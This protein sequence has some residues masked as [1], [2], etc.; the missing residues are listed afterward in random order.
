MQTAFKS[1]ERFTQ[2]EFWEWLQERPESDRNRYELLGGHIIMTP[3]APGYAHSSVAIR[4]IVALAACAQAEGGEVLDSHAGFEFPTG[5]TLE[6]DVTFLSAARFAAG[7][8]PDPRRPLRIMPDLVIEIL[9]PSTAA[10]D[11]TEKKD[12]YA[13]CNVVEFWL[14][15]WRRR[16]V[17]VFLREGGGFG[18][19]RVLRA[20]PIDSRVA[21]GLELSI[22]QLFAG[23]D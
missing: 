9:S 23:F 19:A 11:R 10:R 13:K 21:P 8:K 15:D 20:G 7:P 12:V 16:E 3:P 5:D 22:E 6:P 4:I 1:D 2:S 14:V 18:E 17:T